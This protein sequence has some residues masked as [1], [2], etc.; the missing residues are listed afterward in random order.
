MFYDLHIHSCLSPCAD[1]DMTPANI[2]G[3]AR[4]KGLGMISLT[5][6]NTGGNLAAMDKA[7][8]EAGLEFVPGVEVTSREEV[9]I[10]IYFAALSE[11]LRFTDDLYD[12]LPN[13][14]NR[15][16]IFGRQLLIDQND[17]PM[18][19]L[20]KLLLQASPY[21]VEELC[22]MA[23]S[24]GGAAVPAHVNRDSFSVISNLG[25]IPPGLF[26]YVEISPNLPQPRMEIAYGVLH[27]SDA[28]NLGS[29]SEAENMLPGVRSARDLVALLRA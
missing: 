3:M 16:D 29:I 17:E 20:H 15:S 13:I 28:H 5:D 14:A 7:A 21:S 27:S 23:H 25:F 24:A 10:L 1:D 4:L 22:A 26:K 6:H 19:E 11:A 8:R 2:A 12:S 18:G 9:H